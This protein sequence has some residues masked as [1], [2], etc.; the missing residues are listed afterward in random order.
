MILIASAFYN[1]WLWASETKPTNEL[2][3]TVLSIQMSM[4]MALLALMLSNFVS[5][6]IQSTKKQYKKSM[7]GMLAASF[8]IIALCF[9]MAYD[10]ASVFY[11]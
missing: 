2:S 11:Q 6:I 1:Q 7:I 8:A 3:R 5:V 10:Q 4:V 9:T